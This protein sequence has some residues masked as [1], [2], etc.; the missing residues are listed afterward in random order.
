MRMAEENEA[1]KHLTCSGPLFGENS[2]GALASGLRRQTDLPQL[3]RDRT[4]YIDYT[5]RRRSVTVSPLEPTSSLYSVV[6]HCY[7]IKITFEIVGLCG[8]S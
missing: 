8:R 5:G 4:R 6:S 2:Q 1:L 7:S 3:I